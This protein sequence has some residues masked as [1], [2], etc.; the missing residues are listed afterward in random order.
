MTH[1]TTRTHRGDA[2]LSAVRGGAKRAGCGCPLGRAA[3]FAALAWAGQSRS[4][5]WELRDV[6]PAELF[7][8]SDADDSDY[9]YSDE[10]FF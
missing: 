1:R 10:A 7:A 2:A 5:V 4:R 9:D 3:A 8:D 6:L